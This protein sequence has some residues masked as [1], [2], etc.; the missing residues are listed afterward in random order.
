MKGAHRAYL[1][2]MEDSLLAPWAARSGRSRGRRYAERP[3]AYIGFMAR[4]EFQT[5]PEPIPAPRRPE[6]SALH[7]EHAEVSALAEGEA[8]EDALGAGEAGYPV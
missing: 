8:Q 4:A 6:P 1:E 7:F 5:E 3:H 2:E